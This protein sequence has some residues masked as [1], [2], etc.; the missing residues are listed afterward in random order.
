MSR[1]IKFRA[2]DKEAEQMIHSDDRDIKERGEEYFFS[3]SNDNL[4]CSCLVDCEDIMGYTTQESEEL[5]NIMQYTG[6]KDKNGKEIYEGDIWYDSDEYVTYVCRWD[7]D[8]AR[9]VWESY[10]IPGMMT[11]SGWNEDAG[12]WSHIDTEGIDSYDTKSIEIIGNEYENPEYLKEG[13]C[14]DVDE[15]DRSN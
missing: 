14:A 6:L 12:E 7:D 2:W 3:F 15:T 5:D 13:G 4:S 8:Y 1:E 10:A 9:F 11:E